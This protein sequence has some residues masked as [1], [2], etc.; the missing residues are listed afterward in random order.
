MYVMRLMA[1]H[2]IVM[3]RGVGMFLPSNEWG[4]R[5]EAHNKSISPGLS[6]A[7]LTFEKG[8]ILD[9]VFRG[10]CLGNPP[11]FELAFGLDNALEYLSS[12]FQEFMTYQGIIHQTTCPYT[13]Q[14][15]GVAERKNRHLIETARTLLLESH[16]PLRF[17]GDAVLT[18][19]YLINR[20]PSSSIQNQVPH[21]ILFPES[22]LYH[23]PPRVFGSTCFVHSLAPG[24]DKLAPCALKCVFLGYP[25][26]QKGLAYIQE[27]VVDDWVFLKVSP[28]KG[29]TFLAG[30]PS[31][32][33]DKLD[34]TKLLPG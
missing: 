24:K 5:F 16:V 12:Q 7:I 32:S 20:M 29:V 6:S 4:D 9:H 11:P 15:N 34:L 25:R 8:H 26:V 2:L 27:L 23:I 33:L 13:P 10:R 14:Q 1:T 31:L 19:C 30:R 18:S 3:T 28:M 17:W 21:S 22:H